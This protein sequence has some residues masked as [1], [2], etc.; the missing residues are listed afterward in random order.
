MNEKW[1]SEW[2]NEWV[3]EWVSS[4]KWVSEWMNEWLRNG[5]VSG[6]VSEFI[7]CAEMLLPTSFYSCFSYLR[8]LN[9]MPHPW[10]NYSQAPDKIRTPPHSLCQPLLPLP[11]MQYHCSWQ[12]RGT[13][14]A[15]RLSEA[16][17]EDGHQSVAAWVQI[18]VSFTTYELCDLGQVT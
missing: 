16:A 6:W 8:A 4:E 13:R 5:W 3:N 1:V 15:G 7:F 18:S 2:M 12:Q 14:P 17:S 10:R 9:S 11:N